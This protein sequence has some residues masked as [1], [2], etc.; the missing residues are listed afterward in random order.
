MYSPNKMIGGMVGALGEVAN[1]GNGSVSTGA[2]GTMAQA[3]A[4][5]A[6]RGASGNITGGATNTGATAQQPDHEH[7]S[8][9]S[10]QMTNV[11]PP[12]S[13]TLGQAQP[14]F[15]PQA[16]LTIQGMFGNKQALQNSVGASPLFQR[17]LGNRGAY[18]PAK[19][20]DLI[21][22]TVNDEST[23]R[24]SNSGKIKGMMYD[25]EDLSEI[26]KDKDGQFMVSLDDNEAITSGPSKKVS[27]YSQGNN[28]VRDT[29]RPA[30]G[31]TFY[32]LK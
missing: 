30:V 28:V 31:K 29:L 14:V 1:L 10:Q 8:S 3:A 7:S 6:A 16:N 12:P 21:N 17:Q 24:S 19:P 22:E 11:P 26:Q 15:N 25:V 27:N 9:T 18:K 20:G 32:N 5:A 23:Y 2:R 13:N 4:R